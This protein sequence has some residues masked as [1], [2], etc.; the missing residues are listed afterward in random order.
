MSVCWV[1]HP[2]PKDVKRRWSTI[3]PCVIE[4][5]GLSF[6]VAMAALNMSARIPRLFRT[7]KAPE[8][9]SPNCMIWEAARATSAA[10]TFFER[11]YIDGEPFVDGGMGRNN[12][13]NQ[14]LTETELMFPGQPVACIVSIG[15]GQAETISIPKPRWPQPL[16]Q[17]LLPS[18][19]LPL[20]L[21]DAMRQIATDCEESAQDAA[22]RFQP[23]PG[24]YFRFN[25][26]QGM[27]KVGLE[28][29]EKLD[30]VRAHTRQYLQMAEVNPRLKASVAA[31]ATED[32]SLC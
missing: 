8:Y 2:M 27:Q 28:Q 31:I 29:W 26:N 5:T 22:R 23:T 15:T 14:V 3:V 4:L 32:R 19:V 25:V 24:I 16:F 21:I 10:P 7:Y 20:H 13:I 11:I 18:S 12:P 6:V 9:K 30:E 1:R 17:W